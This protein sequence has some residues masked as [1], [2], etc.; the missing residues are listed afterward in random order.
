MHGLV[1]SPKKYDLLDQPLARFCLAPQPAT[2]CRHSS[3]CL[4]PTFNSLKMSGAPPRWPLHGASSW[5][6][7]GACAQF[8]R[9]GECWGFRDSK[10]HWVQQHPVL[11]IVS[12]F[13]Q[14]K[15]SLRDLQS[16]LLRLSCKA[17]LTI[18]HLA[19]AF[20]YCWRRDIYFCK[21]KHNLY[22]KPKSPS[23][24]SKDILFRLAL[25]PSLQISPGCASMASHPLS[26]SK[27]GRKPRGTPG[28]KGQ[29][30]RRSPMVE[31]YAWKPKDNSLRTKKK[32]GSTT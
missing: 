22:H 26:A 2:L 18:C 4:S 3:I 16:S 27:Q 1:L 29:F 20:T 31:A 12:S 6:L 11:M 14:I 23:L 13:F 17:D 19:H 25:L 28:N 30:S 9:A 32:F 21:D 7:L 24:L 10:C 8:S 15:L 5:F